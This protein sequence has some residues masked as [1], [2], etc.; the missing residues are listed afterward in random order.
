[1]GGAK[2]EADAWA[3]CDRILK[4]FG[5]QNIH[6]ENLMV[7]GEQ[8]ETED[9]DTEELVPGVCPIC[10]RSMPL[11][12]HHLIPKTTHAKYVKQY[13]KEFLN[14]NGVWLCRSCHSHIHKLITEEDMAA[15]YN[16]LDV[17]L[18]HPGVQ[19][20]VPYIKRRKTTDKCDKR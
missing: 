12:F 7:V 20:W 6:A 8:T 5:K 18:S 9:D 17:I 13:T 2:N 3:L 1:L 16:N 10:D 14:S 11:T 19:K 4:E 15:H